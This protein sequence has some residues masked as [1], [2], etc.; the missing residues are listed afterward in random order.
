MAVHRC[1]PGALER[2]IDRFEGALYGYAYG[3]LQNTFDAQEV[4]D[5]YRNV[6]QVRSCRTRCSGR[7]ARSLAS[8]TRRDARRWRSGRGSSR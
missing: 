3:I 1:E 7:T 5:L 2:L 8:T 6:N 4:P